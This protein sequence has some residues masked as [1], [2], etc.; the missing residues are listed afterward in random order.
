MIIFA[1]PVLVFRVALASTSSAAVAG[2]RDGLVSAVC[3]AA[4]A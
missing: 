3:A 4:W 2:A 1:R